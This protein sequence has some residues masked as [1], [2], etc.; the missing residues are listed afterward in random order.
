VADNV[1]G[2]PFGVEASCLGVQVNCACEL[3]QASYFAE[4]MRNEL[5]E[6][7]K[8]AKQAQRSWSKQRVNRDAE[9]P[10]RIVRLK[11]R[12]READRVL[13]ALEKRFPSI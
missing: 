2:E 5:V 10:E 1:A 3:E 8:T 13:K 4:I 7:R 12:V 6:A 9:I 11:S